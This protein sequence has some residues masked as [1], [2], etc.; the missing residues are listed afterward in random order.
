MKL[1]NEAN[2][3]DR[4]NQLMSKIQDAIIKLEKLAPEFSSAGVKPIRA[5]RSML[6]AA[7]Q[8]LKKIRAEMFST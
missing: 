6:E 5:Q 7:E 3:D 8:D 1:I 4:F 2:T